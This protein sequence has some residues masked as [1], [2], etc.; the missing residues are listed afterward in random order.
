MVHMERTP[1]NRECCDLLIIQGGG[2][3]GAHSH[4]IRSMGRRLYKEVD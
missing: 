2:I 1:Q 4:H 3:E